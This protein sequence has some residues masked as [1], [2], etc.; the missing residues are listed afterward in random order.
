MSGKKIAGLSAAAEANNTLLFHTSLLVDF[1]VELMTDIMNTPVVKFQDKGYNCFSQRMTTVRHETNRK[2]S[3][4]ETV[5]A[6]QGAFEEEF[7]VAFKEERPDAWERKTIQNFIDQRY[8]KR[9]GSFPT[10]IPE[11]EW[12]WG[13]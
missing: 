6:V 10:S 4:G 9:N 7:Q 12:A 2:V 11:P 8:T 5:D 1:D 13:S 3:V